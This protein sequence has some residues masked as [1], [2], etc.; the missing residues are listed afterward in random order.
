MCRAAHAKEM[1]PD[2]AARHIK[3]YVNE[4]TLALDEGAVTRMLEFGESEG[5]FA[6]TSK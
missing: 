3:L 2:V 4:Y 5:V 1:D 6:R